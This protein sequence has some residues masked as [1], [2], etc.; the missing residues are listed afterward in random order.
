MRKI[1]RLKELK[2]ILDDKE[3]NIALSDIK[4]EILK[5]EKEVLQKKVSYDKTCF[6][7]QR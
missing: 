5:Q 7:K 4:I 6:E 3:V 2:G 1:W